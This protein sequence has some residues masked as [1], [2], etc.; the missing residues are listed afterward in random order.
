MRKGEKEARKSLKALVGRGLLSERAMKRY[1]LPS[2]ELLAL[3]ES[4]NPELVAEVVAD[5]N[6]VLNAT[7]RAA[8]KDGRH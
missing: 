5:L 3:L 8:G 2:D 7:I 4:P 6:A 1:L